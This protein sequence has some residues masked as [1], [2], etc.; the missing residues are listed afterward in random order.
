MKYVVLVYQDEKRAR[1]ASD[2]EMARSVEAFNKFHEEFGESGVLQSGQRLSH[3]DAATTVR[4]REGKTLITDGPF[5][6]TKEHLAGFYLIEVE[7]LDDAIEFASNVP[8]AKSG[9]IEIRPVF[10]G[11]QTET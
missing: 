9:S 3:S 8:T 7:N 6:E 1:A 5:A 4:V 10:A 11:P 2:E